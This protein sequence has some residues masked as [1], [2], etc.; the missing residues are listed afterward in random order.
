MPGAGCALL[1][2]L[3]GC[4]QDP[5][6]FAAGTRM[7]EHAD[8]EGF[9]VVYPAQAVAANAAGCWNWFDEAHQRRDR[10]EP[11]LIAGITRQVAAQFTADPRRI[12]V[13][14]MSAGAA[15][16]VILGATHP[17]LFAGVGAHSGLPYRAARDAASAFAAMRQGVATAATAA[18]AVPVPTIVFHGD[19]DPIV[20]AANGRRIAEQAV[21]LLN[22]DGH[23]TLEAEVRAPPAANGREYTV[24]AYRR[25][26]APPSAAAPPA[27]EHWAVHGAGHA[28]SGGSSHGSFTDP[29]GPDASAEMIRFFHAHPHA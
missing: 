25:A 12:H 13:G 8:R 4:G 28:W 6:D 23:G 21:S 15:M 16:A 17:E 18:A 14:G 9:L 5:D 24:T 3:H 7:N 26:T 27:V 2:M 11:A 19:D 1:V 20:D 10:G 29:S 22:V